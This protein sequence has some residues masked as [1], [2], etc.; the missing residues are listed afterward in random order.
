[1]NT[2]RI[3]KQSVDSIAAWLEIEAAAVL[4][5]LSVLPSRN[6]VTSRKQGNYVFYS[7]FIPCGILPSLKKFWMPRWWCSTII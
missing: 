6:L 3:S 4:Q 2:L 7:V 5:Q 1:M